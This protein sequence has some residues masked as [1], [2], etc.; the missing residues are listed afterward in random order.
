MPKKWQEY[1]EERRRVTRDPRSRY[2]RLIVRFGFLFHDVHVTRVVVRVR[3]VVL[4]AG[5]LLGST[6]DRDADEEQDGGA[7]DTRWDPAAQ[8]R[9]REQHPGRD[10]HE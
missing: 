3:S 4:V 6:H 10:D 9:H 5:E 8:A 7:C 1:W 2:A